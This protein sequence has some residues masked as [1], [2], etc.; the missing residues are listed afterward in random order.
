MNA[1]KKVIDKDL[2]TGCGICSSIFSN[3]IK[4]NYTGD[5]NRPELIADLT[6]SED[7]TFSYV[8]PGLNQSV[9]N[10]GNGH[11]IWGS[12]VSSHLGYSEDHDIRF[13]A[14][15]GGVITQALI[16]LIDNDLVD[17]VVQI[18]AC[19]DDQLNTKVV[20][21]R[22]ANDIIQSSGSRYCPASPLIN[23]EQIIKETPNIRLCFVGKPCD[24]TAITH[25]MELDSDVKKAIKYKISFFCAGTPSRTGVLNVLSK[26]DIAKESL[27][28]F[29]FRGNGW[30]GKT[31]A[32]TSTD[33]KEL[34]YKNSWGKI[35]GPTIQNRCKICA[36]GIG[37]NADIVSA[38]VWNS[39]DNGYPLFTENDGQGLVLARTDLGHRLVGNMVDDS[40]LNVFDYDIENL[41]NVQPAQYERKGTVLARSLAKFLIHGVIP[42]YKNSRVFRAALKVGLK[43]N[44]RN[45]LGSLIRAKKNKL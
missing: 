19:K 2:C 7:K 40:K 5:Y 31:I 17:A 29:D 12:Y 20:L 30:P 38:D 28:S 13:K 42:N 41:K 24:I 34:N 33:T 22:N 25:L 39:D 11:I 26:L 43:E 35:L 16:Y 3:K 6:D 21:S 23:I 36:D 14:S 1:V 18:R 27:K 4:M 15:S 45:F 10:T 8:C 37:E 9:G 32:K 44:V